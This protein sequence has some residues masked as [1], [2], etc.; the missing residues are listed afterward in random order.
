MQHFR[1]HALNLMGSAVQALL[2]QALLAELLDSLLKKYEE[3][4]SSSDDWFA[5]QLYPVIDSY[6]PGLSEEAH[7]EIALAA[8]DCAINEK[9]GASRLS[10]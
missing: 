3:G 6:A 10:R 7:L 4:A 8:L 9:Y 1:E 5:A 2:P